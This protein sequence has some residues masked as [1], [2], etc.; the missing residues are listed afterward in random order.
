MKQNYRDEAALFILGDCRVLF[1]LIFIIGIIFTE[2]AAYIFILPPHNEVLRR[3]N[4][5][6]T[7]K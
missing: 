3:I 6:Y 5:N 4:N 7:Y 2:N 1:F